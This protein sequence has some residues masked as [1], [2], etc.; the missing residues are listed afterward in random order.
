M[1]SDDDEAEFR[2]FMAEAEPRLRR[3]LI[4]AYGADRGREATAEALAYGWEHW[5]RVRAMEHPTP[6]LFRVGQSRTRRRRWRPTVERP[7]VDEIWSEPGLPAALAA[8]SERQRVVV[9]LHHGYG[10]S[11]R[12]VGDFLGIGKP[13]VQNHLERGMHTLRER[14]TEVTDARP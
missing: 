7:T 12:E 9:V 14:L 13:T 10:W 8:L 2:T 6:Y 1:T 3:A 4:G 11:L 5:S